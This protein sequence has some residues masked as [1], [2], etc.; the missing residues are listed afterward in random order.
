MKRNRISFFKGELQIFK[1]LNYEETFQLRKCAA[2]CEIEEDNQ[3]IFY[4]LAHNIL[5][6]K[7][8]ISAFHK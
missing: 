4:Y 2:L 1:L 6:F 8:S 3:D 5:T 7:L